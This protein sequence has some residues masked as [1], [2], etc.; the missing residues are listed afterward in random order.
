VNEKYGL[1]FGFGNVV[2]YLGE[3]S[4]YWLALHKIRD[5]DV[6]PHFCGYSSEWRFSDEYVVMK[7]MD[8]L[9]GNGDDGMPRPYY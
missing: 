8:Y 7:E 2:I 9:L 6:C 4:K 3:F 1:K 5:R